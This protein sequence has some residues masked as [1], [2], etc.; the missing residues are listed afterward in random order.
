MKIQADVGRLTVLTIVVGGARNGIERKQRA[1]EN[2]HE[3]LRV[4]MASKLHVAGTALYPLDPKAP[5]VCGRPQYQPC[6]KHD[7][8]R[9]S[10]R[11]HVPLDLPEPAER[12]QGQFQPPDSK[13]DDKDRNAVQAIPGRFRSPRYP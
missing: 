12:C 7:A 11:K 6:G 13:R 8:Q 2:V 4:E 10:A 5:V 9:D 3:H 1:P